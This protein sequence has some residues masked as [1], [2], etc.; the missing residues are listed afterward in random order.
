MSLLNRI[1]L[2][3]ALHVDD[4]T[5]ITRYGFLYS[6]PIHL[7]KVMEE[8]I[9]VAAGAMAIEV[10]NVDAML[11]ELVNTAISL[12]NIGLHPHSLWRFM[13]QEHDHAGVT[14]PSMWHETQRR[15]DRPALSRRLNRVIQLS[16]FAVE[17][18]L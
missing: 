7:I 18:F 12:V 5:E 9:G 3:V 6:I 8:D 16:E 2:P 14:C 4:D 15:P 1:V 17:P 11:P 10:M 13:R